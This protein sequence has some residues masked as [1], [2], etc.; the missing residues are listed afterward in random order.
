MKISINLSNLEN[1]KVS[2]IVVFCYQADYTRAPIL[3]KYV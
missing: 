3:E 2:S 1:L